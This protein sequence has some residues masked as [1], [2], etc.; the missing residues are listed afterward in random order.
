MGGGFSKRKLRTKCKLIYCLW[1]LLRG[2]CIYFASI[3]F[4]IAVFMLSNC[5]L[6]LWQSSELLGCIHD[7]ST[8]VMGAADVTD[9][10]EQ[11]TPL[12]SAADALSTVAPFETLLI[13][14]S[15]MKSLVATTLSSAKTNS[16]WSRSKGT[17]SNLPAGHHAWSRAQ[18]QVQRARKSQQPDPAFCSSRDSTSS[19]VTWYDQLGPVGTVAP[20]FV[21]SFSLKTTLR[22]SLYWR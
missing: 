4:R 15:R 5:K 9:C 8:V 17:R 11:P 12:Q 14:L 1:K 16:M 20:N 13:S 18:Q 19:V 6:E 2:S 10:G 3:D 22:R 7:M 21:S